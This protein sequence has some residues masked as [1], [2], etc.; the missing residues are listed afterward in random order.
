M[1]RTTAQHRVGALVIAP[2]PSL[3]KSCMTYSDQHIKSIYLF[4]FEINITTVCKIK[5]LPKLDLIILSGTVIDG[6]RVCPISR[7]HVLSPLKLFSVPDSDL[8][9]VSL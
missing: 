2:L 7:A 4:T 1:Q 5:T 9:L 8:K 3:G 6:G